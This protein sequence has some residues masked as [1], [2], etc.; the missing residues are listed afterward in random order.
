MPQESLI[1][2]N[3][4]TYFSQIS[5]IL[6]QVPRQLLLVFKTNDL[7]RGIEAALR[8]RADATSFLTMS[9]CCVRA[10]SEHQTQVC[11][12]LWCR[13]RVGVTEKWLLAK[14]SVYECY[15]I[16]TGLP[17][18]RYLRDR[19][20]RRGRSRISVDMLESALSTS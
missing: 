13:L 17:V 20:L 19:V 8:T 14:L 4:A 12:S 5:S 11:A 10:V 2:T 9:R 7:L 6:N 15:L 16:V 18:Y 1:R 3:A